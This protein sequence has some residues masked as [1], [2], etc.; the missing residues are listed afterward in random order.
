VESQ[1]ICRST[2]L[3]CVIKDSVLELTLGSSL[4]Q[5]IGIEQAEKGLKF[6]MCFRFETQQPDWLMFIIRFLYDFLN[7]VIGY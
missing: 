6:Q 3:K 1:I 2:K 7:P 5:K 4:K